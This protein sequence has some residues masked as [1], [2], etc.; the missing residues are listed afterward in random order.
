MESPLK[1]EVYTPRRSV[2]ER[3][4]QRSAFVTPSKRKSPFTADNEDEDDETTRTPAFLRR[5]YSRHSNSHSH[6]LNTIPT[7]VR[8][9][10]ASETAAQRFRGQRSRLRA[11]PS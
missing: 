1:G 8:D 7:T 3:D 4:M 9:L 6:S 11:A 2:A 10:D 5:R